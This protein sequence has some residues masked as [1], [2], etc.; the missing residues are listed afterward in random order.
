MYTAVLGSGI[1]LR[2]TSPVPGVVRTLLSCNHEKMTIFGDAL[3]KVICYNTRL[4]QWVIIVYT[5][6]VD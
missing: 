1:L 3:I 6:E 4:F 2:P 5:F